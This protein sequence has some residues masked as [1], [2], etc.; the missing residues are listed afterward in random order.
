MSSHLY[1]SSQGSTTSTPS[2]L[3]SH[4]TLTS[5]LALQKFNHISYMH[6]MVAN[7]YAVYSTLHGGSTWASYSRPNPQFIALYLASWRGSFRLTGMR[8]EPGYEASSPACG[9]ANNYS[10]YTQSTLCTGHGRGSLYV[11][12]WMYHCCMT[13]HHSKFHMDTILQAKRYGEDSVHGYIS[14][15]Y[16]CEYCI[17]WLFH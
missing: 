10:V 6:N 14:D 12:H 7:L 16:Q 2:A 13:H 8:N 15:S 17:C 5:T 11:P 9:H 3:H 1:G 4:C